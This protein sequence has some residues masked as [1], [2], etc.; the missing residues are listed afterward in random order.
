MTTTNATNPPAMTPH[1]AKAQAKAAKAYAKAQRPFYK[2]KRYY[3]LALVAVGIIGTV[4]SGSSNSDKTKPS[5]NAGTKTLSNNGSHPPQADVTLTGCSAD[6]LGYLQAL[7][8]VTN[9]SSGRSNYLIDVAFESKDG[10]T[11]LDTTSAM[12]NNLNS[13]QSSNQTAGSLTKAAGSFTC[14]VTDVN[15]IASF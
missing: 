9:N 11:Q 13:G 4:A 8:K 14:K 3:L 12:V 15:R 2:K 10:A 1:E 6:S 7:V 5:S